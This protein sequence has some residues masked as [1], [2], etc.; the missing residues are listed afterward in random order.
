MN[1]S[2]I[3][4]DCIT[5]VWG[6]GLFCSIVWDTCILCTSFKLI[7]YIWFYL[8]KKY[9]EQFTFFCMCSLYLLALLFSYKTSERINMICRFKKWNCCT[10]WKVLEALFVKPCS[11]MTVIVSSVRMP[12]IFFLGHRESDQYLP[13]I[14]HTF[15]AS[16]T[17]SRPFIRSLNLKAIQS[18]SHHPVIYQIRGMIGLVSLAVFSQL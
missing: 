3:W 12:F 10:V 6:W 2:L 16:S 13:A 4:E 1:E 7:L 9:K 17:V 14:S 15:M 8:F 18:H 11:Y 5:C